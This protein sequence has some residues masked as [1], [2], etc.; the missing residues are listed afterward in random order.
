[1]EK[2]FQ[3]NGE[4][5]MAKRPSHIERARLEGDTELLSAAGRKGAKVAA[6]NR[7]AI[8]MMEE[9]INEQRRNDEFHR[10]QQAGEIQESP[11][12]AIYD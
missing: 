9:R 2:P 6:Q 10:A 12:D 5:P 8:R 7:D 4:T 11:L 3:N 1:M